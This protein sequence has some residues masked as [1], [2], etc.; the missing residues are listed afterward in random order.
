MSN[1]LGLHI[2]LENILFVLPVLIILL[3]VSISLLAFKQI[4]NQ[5]AFEVYPYL[6]K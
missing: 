6:E 5:Y 1:A 4:F 2:T 3:M